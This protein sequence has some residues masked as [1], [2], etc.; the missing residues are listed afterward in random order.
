MGK[1]IKPFFLQPIVNLIALFGLL[2]I[3]PAGMKAKTI[4]LYCG[5]GVDP[6]S[7]H[8]LR[9]T[10][11]LAAP[12][13][14]LECINSKTLFSKDWESD[15]ALFVMP[16]GADRYYAQ[17]LDGEGNRRIRAFVEQGGSYL[18]ICAGSY[19]AGASI[20]FAKGDPT[21]V[22]EERELAL[23]PG[24]VR[25]PNL[26]PFSYGDNTGVRAAKLRKHEQ[27]QEDAPVSITYNGGGYFVDADQ[28]P[29]I[30]I[31]YSYEDQPFNTECCHNPKGEAAIIECAAGEGTAILSAVHPEYAPCD[32]P[33]DDSQAP[34]KSEL[35]A[36]DE[37]RLKLF[38]ELLKRLGIN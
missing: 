33:L 23:F 18:G 14:A 29:H 17:I 38:N 13:Y 27:P 7:L 25:G 3:L 1:V 5:P 6:Y 35:C 31:L 15:A 36:H 20:E 28:M 16:G 8:Q 10:L 11:I 9:D 24:L 4:Y 2:L 37:E 22:I 26:A 12:E 32:L 19:Y 21:E 34:L 30:R